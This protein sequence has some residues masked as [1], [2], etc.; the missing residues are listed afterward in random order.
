MKT[1]SPRAETQLVRLTDLGERQ[2]LDVVLPSLA[3]PRGDLTA[4]GCAQSGSSLAE[5]MTSGG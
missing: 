3:G 1:A 4:L 5:E 2:P